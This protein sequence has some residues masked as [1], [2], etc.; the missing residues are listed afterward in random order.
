[1][2]CDTK[3]MTTI[4]QLTVTEIDAIQATMDARLARAKF[5]AYDDRDELDCDGYPL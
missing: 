2:T 5:S 3:G 4:E 1:M